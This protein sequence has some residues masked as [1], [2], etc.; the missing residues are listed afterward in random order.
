MRKEVPLALVTLTGLFV[1][2]AYYFNYFYELKWLD[3]GNKWYQVFAAM[4]VFLGFINLTQIH[5]RN[6]AR[7]RAKWVYSLILLIAMYG[8]ALLTLWQTV[9]GPQADWIYQN[10]MVPTDATI[11]A[12]LAFFITSAAYRAFRVRTREATVLMISA[13]ILMLGTAPIGDVI[14]PGWKTFSQWILDVPSAAAQRGI[15]LGAYLGAFATALRILLG[16]ERA[17]LGGIEK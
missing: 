12:L 15:L 8:Y 2:V 11:F 17:H 4:F 6:I 14:I 3:I 10:I 5:A 1:I 16:L 13:I 7:R 9:D